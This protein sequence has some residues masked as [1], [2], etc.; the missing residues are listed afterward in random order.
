[1]KLSWKVKLTLVGVTGVMLVLLSLPFEFLS[2]LTCSAAY[3]RPPHGGVP[4]PSLL[5]IVALVGA[6][7]G[8]KK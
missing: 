7:F 5:T 2:S 1:M 3:A 6:Y 4:E 8:F